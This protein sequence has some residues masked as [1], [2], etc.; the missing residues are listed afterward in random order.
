MD[1]NQI[2]QESHS[3]DLTFNTFTLKF[4]SEDL[5]LEWQQQKT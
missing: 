2:E 4:N 1:I 5:N 3:I